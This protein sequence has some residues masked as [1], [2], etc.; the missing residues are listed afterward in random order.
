M[1]NFLLLKSDELPFDL[2]AVQGIF[3]WER[4]FW[5][6]R[7]DEPGGAVIEADYVQAEDW[8]II[9]LSKDLSRISLSGTS[10]AALRAALILQTHITLPL[11]IIDT[12]YSFDL[13][14][15][16]YSNVEELRAAIDKAQA[17]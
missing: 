15:Q 11:R 14:L 9:S 5:N 3:H 10:D 1:R 2:A 8:T 16:D 13:A 12:D 17:N 6:V 4:G 7:F